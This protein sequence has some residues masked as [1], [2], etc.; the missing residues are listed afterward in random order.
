M[1]ATRFLLDEYV[2]LVIQ[3]QLAQLATGLRVYA[4]GDPALVRPASPTRLESGAM[5][6]PSQ[7][8]SR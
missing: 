8:R 1:T 4:V 6:C 5:A 7:P 3:A 2:S